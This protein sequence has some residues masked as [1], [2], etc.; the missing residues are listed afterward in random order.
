M[1]V[2][3]AGAR[4]FYPELAAALKKVPAYSYANKLETEKA[5]NTALH[6]VKALIEAN[7]GK[8]RNDWQGAAVRIFGLRATS[9]SGLEAACWNWMTQVTLKSMGA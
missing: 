5:R 8:I 9:T 7:G 2:D 4:A 6:A 1:A 3:L